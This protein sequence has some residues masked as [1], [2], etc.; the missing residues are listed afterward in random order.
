MSEELPP[1]TQSLN[2]ILALRIALQNSL[3]AAFEE[4]LEARPCVSV[5]GECLPLPIG[6]AKLRYRGR[7]G[8]TGEMEKK[9]N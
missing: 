6:V 4:L 9:R 8:T 1:I 2:R 5:F 3:F 7:F